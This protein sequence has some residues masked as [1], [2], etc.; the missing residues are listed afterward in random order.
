MKYNVRI[1]SSLGAG[2]VRLLGATWR[3]RISGEEHVAAAR[4]HGRTVVWAFWHGRMLPLSYEYR[5]RSIH[6][7]ASRHRDGELM[8]R[9]V[10]RLGF[11]HVR[12]SSTRGGA[13]AIL[14]LVDKLKKGYDLGLTVDGPLGP[15]HVFK[16][17]PLEIS[18]LSGC[19]VVPVA[20]SSQR[21]WVFT[22]WDAF[23]LPWPFT[24]VSVCFGRPA[25]V[26]ANAGLDEI[27]Q[28]RR[29]IET[30]LRELTTQNDESVRAA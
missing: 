11:G 5:D 17:G 21:H 20:V 25:M 7:L 18:K 28:K 12:G 14:E 1:A 2:L 19:A 16:P 24:R 15:R 10:R 6:V 4:S 27:E 30:V 23:E 22:S 29:E 26:P 8:G 13:Q 9:I 3:F